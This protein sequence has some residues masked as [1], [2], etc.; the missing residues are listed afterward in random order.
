MKLA[1]KVLAAVMAI[2]MIAGLSAMAFAAAPTVS[3]EFGEV[4]DGQVKMNVYFDN[5]VGLKSWDIAINYD[6]DVLTFKSMSKGADAKQIENTM[7][8]S[9]TDEKNTSEAG[10][11][12]YSG[13]FKENLW[14][15]KTFADNAA[16]AEEAPVN[17]NDTH[18][19]AATVTFIVA[20]TDKASVDV[21][22]Q[23]TTAGGD[24]GTA[25]L[26]AGSAKLVLKEE[27]A[28]EKPATEKPVTEKPVTEKPATEKPATEKPATEKPATDKPATGEKEN[29]WL[30]KHCDK[31]WSFKEGCPDCEKLNP[32]HCDKHDHFDC[33][34][35]DCEK[36]NRKHCDKHECF[37]DG[38]EACKKACDTHKGADKPAV[39]DTTKA[40]NVNTGDNMALAAAGA[41]V[42]LAGAAFVISKKRK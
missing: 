25:G 9:F 40:G 5:S 12:L 30:V 10:K 15:S 35:K 6:A 14:D 41:V 13:Y 28:T 42:V 21:S 22:A 17:V 20:S 19:H 8:N 2:A 7:D 4:K 26:T 24:N 29:P 23:V 27:P 32:M 11:I 39:K 34:C 37:K 38:C 36:A 16:D 1:K 3:F 33:D 18:F 31:H